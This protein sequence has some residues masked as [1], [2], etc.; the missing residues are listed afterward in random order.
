MSSIEWAKVPFFGEC[1]RRLI[2]AGD[3]HKRT[4]WKRDELDVRGKGNEYDEM[5]DKKNAEKDGSGVCRGNT[6]SD[7]RREK[8]RGRERD[9][10]AKEENA[11]HRENEKLAI[12]V[13]VVAKYSI[14]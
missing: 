2:E 9:N 4:K 10:V 14:G 3:E 5:W 12:N 11:R 1:L 13:Y 8:E 7:S 6:V